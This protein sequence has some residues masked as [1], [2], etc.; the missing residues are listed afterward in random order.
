MKNT[1]LVFIFFLAGGSL[2]S[3]QTIMN[4][5]KNDGSV[6]QIPMN[7]IDSIT[8]TI[9]NPGNPALIFTD[10]V[11][12]ITSNT[13]TCGGYITDSGGTPITERGIVWSL[14][15]NPTTA[16]SKAV[17]GAGMGNFTAGIIGLTGT[18]TY[19]VRAY[20]INSAGTAYGNEVTF[21][22]SGSNIQS[23]PG[24]GVTFD[25]YTYA[26]IV[27]GNG[28]EWMAENLRTSVYANGDT[29]ANILNNSEWL[30]DTMGA[31]A[32]Y[33]NTAQYE[34]P[35]GKL[36]NW[37]AAIDPRNVCPT[38]WHVPTDA[39]WN[40]LIGYLDPNFDPNALTQSQIAGG[41]MK[42]AGSQYWQGTNPYGTNQSGFSG[43]PGGA[44][45]PDFWALGTEGYW[46]SSTEYVSASWIRKLTYANGDVYR[47][48][49]NT[50]NGFSIRCLK[51]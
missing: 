4:I 18:T 21:T 14:S 6:V 16:N 22:S 7:T 5:H 27:L 1:F 25:G 33:N 12:N 45:S 13:A 11:S 47:D 39:E 23:N 8:Y 31:W 20:A 30:V 51:D 34:N 43:L 26:S 19:Y 35:Y 32:Y 3:G 40:T 42:T 46:W 37:F 36:Y 41:Y 44:R 49:V 29:I 2:V 50:D 28:Q 38:G 24:A 15:P 17:A 48:A 9:L 10:S